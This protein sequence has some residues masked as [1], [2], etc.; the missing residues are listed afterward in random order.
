[1]TVPELFIIGGPNGSGKTTTAL[2]YLR[3]NTSLRFLSADAIAEELSPEDPAL[4]AVAA[5]KLFS[6]R[7][8]DALNRSESVVVESTLSG[9]TLGRTIRRAT[10]LGYRTTILFVYLAS[11][12]ECIARIKERVAR[13]GH[14]VPDA[15]VVRRFSPSLDNFWNVYREMVSEWI[16]LYNGG[17][18]PVRIASGGRGE[19]FVGDEAALANFLR[20]IG[21]QGV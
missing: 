10:S 2:Q 20:L 13:G 8:S 12:Q 9:L 17:H 18:A 15:D 3:S 19:I 5:G 14:S 6:R 21:R 16:L 7:L 4:A 1:V 11:T